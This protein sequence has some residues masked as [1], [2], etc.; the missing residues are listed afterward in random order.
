MKTNHD[1]GMLSVRSLLQNLFI[2]YPCLTAKGKYAKD[3]QVW[4]S[5]LLREL[6]ACE[7]GTQRG[8]GILL[9][10]YFL[11]LAPKVVFLQYFAIFCLYL[12]SQHPKWRELMKQRQPGS[13]EG[14]FLRDGWNQWEAV[15][16]AVVQWFLKILC[17]ADLFLIP[18]AYSLKG[19]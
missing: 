4:K 17:R 6:V 12:F 19:H 11:R 8:T 18:R 3:T 2:A 7:R 16:F 14:H 15:W 5:P 9:F 10:L 1:L 13:G